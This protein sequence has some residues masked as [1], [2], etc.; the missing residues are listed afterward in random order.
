[1][2]DFLFLCVNCEDFVIE[3]LDCGFCKKCSNFMQDLESKLPKIISK[4]IVKV[5][6]QGNIIPLNNNIR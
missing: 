6:N 4:K 3:K 2:S 1:M 5:G